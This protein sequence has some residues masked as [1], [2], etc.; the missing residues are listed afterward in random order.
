MKKP[1]LL[2]MLIAVLSAGSAC[3]GDEP[4]EA[5]EVPSNDETNLLTQAPLSNSGQDSDSVASAT[6]GMSTLLR[7]T[8]IIPGPDGYLV[9]ENFTD[10][11]VTLAGQH[12]CQGDMCFALPDEV[13]PSGE[14]IIITTGDG[15][16]LE[17]LVVSNATIGD[18]RPADGEI[19]LYAS[20][21]WDDPQALLTYIEWGSTPHELTELAIEAGVWLEGSYAPAGANATRLYRDQDSGLWLWDSG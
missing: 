16:A 14:T 20:T 19:G 8:E 11:P 17:G 4:T 5:T 1:L 13:V 12:L 6:V 10:V 3:G 18:I 2:F 21:E 15:E 9:L 7:F